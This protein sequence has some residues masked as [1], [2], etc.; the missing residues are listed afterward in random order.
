MPPSRKTSWLPREIEDAL[1][2]DPL[3]DLGDRI[4]RARLLAVSLVA[5][6]QDEGGR[7]AER[8]FNVVMWRRGGLGYALV[9]DVDA[10]ELR[11]LAAKLIARSRVRVR[12][13][14]RHRSSGE[15]DCS[16]G[17]SD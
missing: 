9:S 11:D 10:G 2:P 17:R 5:G 16:P 8:G 13:W 15:I 12:R 7:R 1:G 3:E 14:R 6:V 4:E